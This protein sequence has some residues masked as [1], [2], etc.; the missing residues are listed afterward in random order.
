MANKEIH[1]DIAGFDP[2]DLTKDVAGSDD[3][4]AALILKA[5]PLVQ[6]RI[7][8]LLDGLIGA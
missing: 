1:G 5:R 4:H 8:A 6:K 7:A 2:K 3:L